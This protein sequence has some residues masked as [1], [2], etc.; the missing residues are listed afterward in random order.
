MISNALFSSE[1][2]TWTTPQNLFNEL[3]NEFH[4]DLDVCCSIYTTKCRNF[5][6]EETDGLSQDWSGHVCWMNPPYGKYIYD[7]MKKS[8]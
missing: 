6:T 1:D 7:W 3:N 2:M 8:L 4:F 5:F